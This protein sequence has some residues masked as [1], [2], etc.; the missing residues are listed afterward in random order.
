[1]HGGVDDGVLALGDVVGLEP[2]GFE[3]GWV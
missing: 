3:A 1:V 2:D